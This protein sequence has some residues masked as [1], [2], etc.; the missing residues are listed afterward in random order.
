MI[1]F[2][3]TIQKNNGEGGEKKEKAGVRLDDSAPR[4]E[5]AKEVKS[6]GKEGF[7]ERILDLRRVTRVVAGGKRFRFRAAVAIGDKNGRVGFG[8]AKGA[9]VAGAVSKAKIQ[10]EKHIIKV[11]LKGDTIPYDIEI[12]YGSARVILKPAK[13]GHGL[14]AG[15]AVR[16][17]CYL[18]GI[19]DLSAKILSHTKNPLNN[20]KATIKALSMLKIK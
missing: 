19:K 11:P 12:K 8:L 6:I 17:I 13:K 1:L 2:K 4:D 20:A 3:K 16:I 15:G 9:D 7:E 5:T 18:A 14:V 10:A